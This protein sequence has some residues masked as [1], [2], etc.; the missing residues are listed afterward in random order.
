MEGPVGAGE[1][2]LGFGAVGCAERKAYP[3][4]EGPFQNGD[5]FFVSTALF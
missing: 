2:E 1:G 5:R 4:V 3:E